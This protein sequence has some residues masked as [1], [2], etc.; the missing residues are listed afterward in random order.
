VVVSQPVSSASEGGGVVVAQPVSDVTCEGV[1]KGGDPGATSEQRPLQRGGQGWWFRRSQ[2]AANG[3]DDPIPRACVPAMFRPGWVLA[4]LF[5]FGV[6][7]GFVEAVVVVDLRAVLHP[8]SQLTGRTSSDGVFPLF[9]LDQLDLAD[10]VAGRLMRIETCREAATL[11]MLAGAGLAAGRNFLQRFAAFSIAFGVWDLCYYLALKLLLAWPASMWTWDVLFLIPVPWAAPVLAPALVATSMVIAGSTVL[12]W[13]STGRS[14]RLGRWHWAAIVAGGLILFASFCW[15]WRTL[16][17]GGLP[18][19]FPWPLFLA[20]EGLA[21]GAVLHAFG[22]SRKA[23]SPWPEGS[24]E[25][26]NPGLV[27]VR[28]DR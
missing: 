23:L 4:G 27:A 12:L 1:V 17:G 5:L 13:E 9:T 2:L 16:A 8:I 18:G 26:G 14:F 25:L 21:C 19:T 6:G 3:L 22:L 20:G 7:F 10:P 24:R 11:V 28:A 15:D